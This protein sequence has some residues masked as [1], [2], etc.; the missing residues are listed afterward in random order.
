MTILVNSLPRGS[1]SSLTIDSHIRTM[2]GEITDLLGKSGFGR[3]Y[4]DAVDE[5]F[6]LVNPKTGNETIWFLADVKR[7]CDGDI[8]H[9]ELRPLQPTPKQKGWKMFLLND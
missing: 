8:D 7:D 4:D 5:G 6:V 2:V 3:I 9:F 1:I